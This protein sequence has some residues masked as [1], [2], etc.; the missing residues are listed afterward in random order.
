MEETRQVTLT[1]D[2]WQKIDYLLNGI[3]DSD[4]LRF[5]LI[6]EAIEVERERL[7]E[8]LTMNKYA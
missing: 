7:E 3:P 1:E 8:Q 6:N 4:F 5:C 2:N